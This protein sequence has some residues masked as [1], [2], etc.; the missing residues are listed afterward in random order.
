MIKKIDNVPRPERQHE[1][2]HVAYAEPGEQ[3]ERGGDFE[4]AEQVDEAIEREKGQRS[5]EQHYDGAGVHELQRPDPEQDDAE[6]DPQ[7]RRRDPL[8]GGKQGV[9][10]VLLS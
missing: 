10:D 8:R 7:E 1:Q 6:A 5:L 2:P 9:H 4:Y 3:G